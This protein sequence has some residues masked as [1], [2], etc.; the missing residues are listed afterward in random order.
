MQSEWSNRANKCVETNTYPQPTGT[1]TAAAGSPAYT[2]NFT[3]SVS[4]SDDTTFRYSWSFGDGSSST[5]ANPSHTYASAGS[6]NVTLTVFD[7]HGDQL[8]VVKPVAV[9]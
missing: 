8:H 7:A 5:S 3:S 1:F 6:E 9:S 2:E 4:D